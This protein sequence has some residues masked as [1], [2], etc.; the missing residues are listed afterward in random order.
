MFPISFAEFPIRN[1]D[2]KKENKQNLLNLSRMYFWVC[3]NRTKFVEFVLEALVYVRVLKFITIYSLNMG[4][5][6]NDFHECTAPLFQIRLTEKVS[7]ERN[8]HKLR[9]IHAF[10]F[11]SIF[12]SYIC[13]R[14]IGCSC[15]IISEIRKHLYNFSFSILKTVGFFVFFGWWKPYWNFCILFLQ[16]RSHI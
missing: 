5:S 6:Q 1:I 12:Y 10:R 15:C 13:L 8:T 3:W 11:K 7:S 16:Y 9:F 4:I 14:S 2:F